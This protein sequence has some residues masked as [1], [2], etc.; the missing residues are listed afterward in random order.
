MGKQRKTFLFPIQ[1]VDAAIRGDSDALQKIW[2]DYEPYV[3]TLCG[4]PY[5]DMYG[6]VHYMIDQDMKDYLREQ[7][8][9]A[10]THNFD[11]DYGQK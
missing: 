6:N 7:L 8:Y 1:V 10:I 4:R 9:W 2:R 5:Q 3:N 11:K